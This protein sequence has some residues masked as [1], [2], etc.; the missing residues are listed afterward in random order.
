MSKPSRGPRPLSDILGELLLCGVMA[1]YGPGKN[2]RMPGTQRWES[3]TA[4]KRGWVKSGV[5]Y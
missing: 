4:A 2:W 5:G 1:A 3:Q